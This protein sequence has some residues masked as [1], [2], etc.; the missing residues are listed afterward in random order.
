MA[1]PS[2]RRGR[3]SRGRRHPGRAG[4]AGCAERERAG[5][6]GAVRHGMEKG[7]VEAPG[8]V[9]DGRERPARRGPGSHQVVRRPDADRP[10]GGGPGGPQ[11]RVAVDQHRR[12]FDGDAVRAAHGQGDHE[13]CGRLVAD[14]HDDGVLVAADA[15]DVLHGVAT[16]GAQRGADDRHRVDEPLADSRVPGR[17]APVIV[18]ADRPVER[19]RRVERLHG[20]TVV[21][22]GL[23]PRADRADDRRGHRMPCSSAL[24]SR[25]MRAG[26]RSAGRRPS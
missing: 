22:P 2:P 23:V 9:R 20:A 18:G 25:S 6:G 4:T 8:P 12:V 26:T 11:R 19:P 3:R 13:G 10:A 21:D 1:A 7:G 14:L 15:V 24:A 5:E 16:W 17:V